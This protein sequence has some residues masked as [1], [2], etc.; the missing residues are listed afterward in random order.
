MAREKFAYCFPSKMAKAMKVIDTRTQHEMTLLSTFFIMIGLVLFTDYLVIYGN[1]SIW[2]KILT[3][4]NALCG[5]AFMF[6]ALITA[7]QQYVSLM[8][9][10]ELIKAG[11]T[12]IEV[13]NL[14][15]IHYDNEDLKGGK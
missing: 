3:V 12:N 7:Y 6:A 4:F 11:T 10:E 13:L 2:F 14:N 15:P 1:F 5:L 9:M 8:Q